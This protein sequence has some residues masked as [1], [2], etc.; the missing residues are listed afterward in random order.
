LS[1]RGGI[2][3]ILGIPVNDLRIGGGIIRRRLS[4]TDLLSINH[5]RR[6]QNLRN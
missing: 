1:E 4:I 6:M 3:E 5:T 2:F